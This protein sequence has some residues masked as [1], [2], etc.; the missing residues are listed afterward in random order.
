MRGQKVA[1]VKGAAV[2]KGKASDEEGAVFT[3]SSPA[4]NKAKLDSEVTACT[5][6]SVVV[7]SEVRALQCDKCVEKW[8]CIKC[9]GISG[10]VYDGLM[11]CKDICWFCMGCGEVL[12]AK[13][14]DKVLAVLE[15]VMDK[16]NRL[17]E[18]LQQK[19]DV[20]T[21]EEQE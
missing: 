11:D 5:R 9:L 1:L 20:N 13:T 2:C 21:V 16:L 8:K 17:E 14:K 19:V 6:C 18:R 4:F 10:K 3:V 7:T 15:K 12:A